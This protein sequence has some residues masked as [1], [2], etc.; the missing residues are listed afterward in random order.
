M[1]LLILGAVVMVVLRVRRHRR[2][3]VTAG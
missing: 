2:S 3:T 1:G